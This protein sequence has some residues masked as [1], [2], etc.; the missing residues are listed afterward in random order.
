MHLINLLLCLEEK[1][2]NHCWISKRTYP[3]RW[4]V[5]TLVLAEEGYSE[6]RE[7]NSRKMKTTTISHGYMTPVREE[8]VE[9]LSKNVYPLLNISYDCTSQKLKNKTTS[10][11]GSSLYLEKVPWLRLIT[12]PL[13]FSRLRRCD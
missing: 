9:R 5:E 8:K 13:E 11:P 7:R 2:I 12:C 10:F 6:H 4:K 3:G 1:A